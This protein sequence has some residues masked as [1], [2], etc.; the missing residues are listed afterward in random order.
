[1]KKL[2]IL[3]A[4]IIFLA[5]TPV[6]NA[7][8]NPADPT[9]KLEEQLL[10]TLPD[11]T[12]NPNFSITFTDPSGEG[13]FLKIDG[14]DFIQIDNPHVLPSLG[15]GKHTLTFKFTDNEEST[16]EV[17]QPLVIV[18]RSTTINPPEITDGKLII[19]GKA[20]GSATINLFASGDETNFQAV[21]QTDAIGDWEYISTKE[22]P[23]GVYTI[24]AIV[25][26]G[27]YS[28]NF[29]EPKVFRV[30]RGDTSTDNTQDEDTFEF[31]LSDLS[32]ED[33]TISSLLEKSLNNP[34]IF[35]AGFIL[36]IFGLFI[37]VLLSKIFASSST[38]KT[39]KLFRK[40][41]SSESSSNKILKKEKKSKKKKSKKEDKDDQTEEEDTP[42]SDIKSKLAALSSSSKKETEK[43]EQKKDENEDSKDKKKG[44]QSKDEKKKDIKKEEDHSHNM[45]E[46]L[47]SEEIEIS[48]EDFLNDFKEFDP[49]PENEPK[50][51]QD[52]KDSI[53]KKS[54]KITKPKA[55][56]KKTDQ[57]D[58]AKKEKKPKKKSKK[59][60]ST[61]V[62]EPKKKEKNIK[63]TLTSGD[64]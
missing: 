36:I 46:K 54:S 7:Q 58:N 64:Q 50:E 23:D 60:K 21:T 27:G 51:T 5:L 40:A 35:I 28:S 34:D 37:G 44:K 8:E 55:S 25:K 6:V 14:Q 45:T 38:K 31:S 3:A 32:S 42:T 29:S 1:M 12:E 62:E 43:T 59:M 10:L 9:V 52:T 20:V 19:S 47:A 26:K 11:E 30:S 57:K 18:P 22:M 53:T 48:K 56:K 33:L 15:I 16:H 2:P 61:P 13:V 17:E 39:E 24:T 49:D 4:L 41:L 63:I